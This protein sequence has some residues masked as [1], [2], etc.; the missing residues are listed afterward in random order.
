MARRQPALHRLLCME[1]GGQGRQDP[2][3][4]DHRARG[5]HPGEVIA[6]HVHDHGEFCLLLGILHELPRQQPVQLAGCSPGA[7]S[8]DRPRFHPSTLHPQKELRG[9]RDHLPRLAEIQQGPIP[10]GVVSPKTKGAFQ[11]RTRPVHHEAPGQVGL[12]AGPRTNGCQYLLH[13]LKEPRGIPHLRQVSPGDL[14][15]GHLVRFLQH[16]G[17]RFYKGG[18]TTGAPRLPIPPKCAVHSPK[19]KIR[20]GA[21]PLGRRHLLTPPARLVAEVS[22]H[23]SRKG[24][25]RRHGGLPEKATNRLRPAR[26]WVHIQGRPPGEDRAPWPIKPT[27][28]GLQSSDS[29]DGLPRRRKLAKVAY[30]AGQLS[31]PEVSGTPLQPAPRCV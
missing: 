5:T 21:R 14:G 31:R 19:G 18:R 26:P 9:V 12:V 27:E 16:H 3:G 6:G 20:Q 22:D 4:S 2:R 24:H 10:G 25:S 23:P 29:G 28:P 13:A 7:R 8:L 11:R 30:H 1:Q 17:G 15:K